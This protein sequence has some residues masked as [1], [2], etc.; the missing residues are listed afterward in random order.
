MKTMKNYL[1]LL[2]VVLSTMAWTGCSEN[3][4]DP[5]PTSKKSIVILH[6][7]DVHCAVDG[8]SKMAGLRNAIVAADTAHV[9]I[10]SSGDFINGRLI[11]TLSRGYDIIDIMNAVGYEASTLGN[12]AFDYGG[13]QLKELVAAF[14][15]ACISTNFT[16]ANSDKTVFL[17][18]F[19][20]NLG[21]RKIAFLGCTTPSC[22]QSAKAIMFDK[23]GNPIYTMHGADMASIVQQHVDR[24]RAEG[25]DYVILLSHLGEDANE[26]GSEW[27]SPRLI[28]DTYGI[29]A[30]FDAHTHHVYAD[31]LVANKSGQYVHLTQTGT[32]FANIGKMWISADGKSMSTSLIP[33]DEVE[34]KDMAIQGLVDEMIKELEDVTTTPFGIVDFEML[35]DGKDEKE[36]I[37]KQ[38]TNM[39]DFAADAFAYST[40]ADIGIVQ[41]GSMKHNLLPGPITL[42]D[43]INTFIFAN[44][45]KKLSVTGKQV[46]DLLTV[47]T[48]YLPR[49]KSMFP[50]VSG[51]KFTAHITEGSVAIEDLQVINHDT[52]QYV[53][54]DENAVYTLAINEYYIGAQR[55]IL[56]SCTELDYGESLEDY[57]C[58]A[59]FITQKWDGNIPAIYSAPQGRITIKDDTAH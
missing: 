33:I 21:D 31:T 30:V 24:L 50:Q 4:A 1:T 13:D 37:R 12:H 57:T 2:A 52:N 18:Y 27:I 41:S 47:I 49:G 6:D 26:A 43:L 16:Y 54:I 36:I 45:V 34:T 46:K 32:E 29:D 14:D 23:D 28:K 56:G 39:G 44:K 8:Y 42:A 11:G 17:P 9:M 7:N 20:K 3:A 15:G 53:P 40:G 22:M 55:E 19:M 10:V 51:I 59:L 25:A 48:Q 35:V 5:T 58:V 38:E